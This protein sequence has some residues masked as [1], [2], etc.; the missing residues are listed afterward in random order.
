MGQVRPLPLAGSLCRS[1][2]FLSLRVGDFADHHETEVTTKIPRATFGTAL[3]I[4]S[5]SSL[6]T[7][8]QLQI[9]S[10]ALAEWA[11][12]RMIMPK[13]LTKH[14]GRS[15]ESGL[16][17]QDWAVRRAS[18]CWMLRLSVFVGAKSKMHQTD[19]HLPEY[20]KSSATWPS[21]HARDAILQ[22][23]SV[24]AMAMCLSSP[25]T[26]RNH[27]VALKWPTH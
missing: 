9:L 20:G 7:C 22:A 16:R 15:R 23:A 6:D 2:D 27:N 8:R 4:Q 26:K 3:T 17:N 10:C 25:R 19:Q 1:S 13:R 21:L 11:R 14:G 18:K 5:T 12:R 24:T